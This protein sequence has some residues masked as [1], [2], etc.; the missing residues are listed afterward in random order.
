L[1]VTRCTRQHEACC[2]SR[3]GPLVRVP[4]GALDERDAA[5]IRTVLRARVADKRSTPLVNAA[6]TRKCETDVVSMCR[7]VR[8]MPL[9]RSICLPGAVSNAVFHGVTSALLRTQECPVRRMLVS[10]SV[11]GSP[12]VKVDCGRRGGWTVTWAGHPPHATYRTLDPALRAA[13]THVALEPVD[14]P[15]ELIVRDAYNRVLHREFIDGSDAA[16]RRR[17]RSHQLL[18]IGSR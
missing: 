4:G 7:G 6:V 5:D 14:D 11:T 15:V 10:V 13:R 16:I 8:A 2:P 18:S 1:I 17:P 3:R 12:M 9:P